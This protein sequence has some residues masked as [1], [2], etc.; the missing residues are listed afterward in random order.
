MKNLGA[1]LSA[2]CVAA[3]MACD[4]SESA[5]QTAM[6]S[7][8]TVVTRIATI[9]E[10]EGPEEYLFGDIT[11][12]AADTDGRIYVADRIGSSVRAY[13]STGRHLAWI[14]REG[15][16]PGEFQ[17]PNDL[18]FDPAGRLFVRDATRITQLARPAG[19]E[20]PDSVVRTLRLP[21][22]ANLSSRRARAGEVQYYYPAYL[23]RRG[24]P[25]R[26]FYLVFDST[27]FV[28]DT[29]QVPPIRT[30]QNARSA[31]YRISQG[32]GRM[33]DG[34]NRAPFEAGASW[35]LTADGHVVSTTGLEYRIVETDGRGDTIRE[36]TGPGGRRPV[37]SA[38]KSD[39]A[40]ALQQRIDSLPV[41]LGDVEGV[42]EWIRE[43]TLPDSL[44]ATVA[45]HV[46]ADGKIWV[47]RWPAEGEGSNTVF[48]IFTRGGRYERTVMVP[49]PLLNDPPPHLSDDL[50]VGVVQDP[51][52]DV[53]SVLV[54]NATG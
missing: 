48:D 34:L 7:D 3:L 13:H 8:T 27:G 1:C 12:V 33:V 52:T 32:S 19:S 41:P 54:F 4:S 26:Y 53:E 40:A 2:A 28:G 50:I 49:A 43:G 39:S 11:S 42:S 30:L 31:F 22:Y 36:F 25:E 51:A 38:E 35:D 47:G 23:F 5:S 20:L 24:E 46:S 6:S 44:P 18:V 45:L 37:P 29:I 21:G 14:G 16:G 17:W 9:G 15:E 10:L